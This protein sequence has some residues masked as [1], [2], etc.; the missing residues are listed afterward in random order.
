MF[1]WLASTLHYLLILQSKIQDYPTYDSFETKISMYFNHAYFD[2]NCAESPFDSWIIP[3]IEQSC[4]PTMSQAACSLNDIQKY[5][6]DTTC[7]E[8][9][10][11]QTKCCP[12]EIL[13]FQEDMKD[14]CPY[15]QCRLAALKAVYSWMKYVCIGRNN[16]RK[17]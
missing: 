8:P 10:W 15:Q 14:A 1:Y 9:T 5:T 11:D 12:S 16:A 6:C 2:G 17:E 7:L 3:W 13:C 4:P